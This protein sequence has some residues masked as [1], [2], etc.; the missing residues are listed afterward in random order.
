[1]IFKILIPVLAFGLIFYLF[2]KLA[3]Q[4]NFNKCPECDGLG[5]WVGT[6]GDKN[7]CKKCNGSG[8]KQR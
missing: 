5:Y 1:M 2:R 4:I 7:T 6:R 3:S 8:K